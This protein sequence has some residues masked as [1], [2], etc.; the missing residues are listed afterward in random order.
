[1]HIKIDTAPQHN[2]ERRS[3]YVDNGNGFAGVTYDQLRSYETLYPPITTGETL[4]LIR[5][6]QAGDE[7]AA[8]LLV[9]HNARRIM[10]FAIQAATGKRRG[11]PK[12]A[13]WATYRAGLLGIEEC[14]SIA[15]SAFWEA[16]MKFDETRWSPVA[17]ETVRFSSWA[18]MILLQRL[19]SALTRAK[20]RKDD[21]PM[22][23]HG[24]AAAEIE[25]HGEASEDVDNG[26]CAIR[27]SDPVAEAARERLWEVI[28][29]AVGKN[30]RAVLEEWTCKL[31][32]PRRATLSCAFYRTMKEL[33][34]KLDYE[35]MEA[36]RRSLSM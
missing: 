6:A 20:K 11:N 17:Q 26:S 30:G 28:E 1:M 33:K 5:L 23:D 24:A 19:G 2:L 10:L 7:L 13:M 3:G 31:S 14:I 34:R 29:G 36:I 21:Y 4:R 8:E 18:N 22:E 27:G 15:T 9:K 12:P 32:R 35:E 16:I 25:D